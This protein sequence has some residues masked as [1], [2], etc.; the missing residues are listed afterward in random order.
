MLAAAPA[1]PLQGA[2]YGLT[3][4]TNAPATFGLVQLNGATGAGVVVGPAHKEPETK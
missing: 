4:V 2:F 3:L 1:I